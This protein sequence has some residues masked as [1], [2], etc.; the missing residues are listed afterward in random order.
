MCF[1]NQSPDLGSYARSTGYPIQKLDRQ[2]MQAAREAWCL[3]RA[4][5]GLGDLQSLGTVIVRA[6]KQFHP[7]PSTTYSLASSV[8]LV[9]SL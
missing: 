3:A 1:L 9:A 8:L 2:P 5:G 6:V 7:L 4:R